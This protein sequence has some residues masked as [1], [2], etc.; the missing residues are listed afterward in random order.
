VSAQARSGKTIVLVTHHLSD[1]IP[2]MERV[3]FLKGG[4]I[5]DDGPKDKML[6]SAKMSELFG[7]KLEVVERE[8]RYALV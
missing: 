2:E 7:A 6:T 1:I 8:G 5:V 4:Q 3:A